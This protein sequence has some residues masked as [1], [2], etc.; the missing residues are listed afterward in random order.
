MVI[1]LPTLKLPSD[2]LPVPALTSA[3][4][5]WLAV[6]GVPREITVMSPLLLVAPTN[7][8]TVP[9]ARSTLALVM[10]SALPAP[11]TWPAKFL[12]VMPLVNENAPTERAA[13]LSTLNAAPKVTAPAVSR[14]KV[15]TLR[16]DRAI[17]VTELMPPVLNPSPIFNVGVVMVPSSAL[18]RPKVPTASVPPRLMT[19]AG[20]K[21]PSVTR[22]PAP[23]AVVAPISDMVSAV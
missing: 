2:T 12:M 6:P 21:A 17:F 8:S 9:T 19:V 3:P 11:L 7:P 16:F 10:K 23:E 20:E 15:G 13:R 1:V 14:L 4:T 22:L 5:V 18:V